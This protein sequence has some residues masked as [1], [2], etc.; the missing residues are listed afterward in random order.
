[1]P[2]LDTAPC[3]PIV[4]PGWDLNLQTAACERN[5]LAPEPAVVYAGMFPIDSTICLSI[6]AWQPAN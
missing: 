3:I 5:T 6:V 4:E 1:M 2:E